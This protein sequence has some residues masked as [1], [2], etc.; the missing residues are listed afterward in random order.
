MKKFILIAMFALVTLQLKAQKVTC[1][2]AERVEI[3]TWSHTYKQF[4]VTET[5]ESWGIA[6][7]CS[8]DNMVSFTFDGKTSTFFTKS[9][10]SDYVEDNVHHTTWSLYAG[11]TL[12]TSFKLTEPNYMIVSLMVEDTAITYHIPEQ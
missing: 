10:T 11:G 1:L 4:F 5:V 6:Q 8:G 2:N 3:K 7:F 9:K 12:V